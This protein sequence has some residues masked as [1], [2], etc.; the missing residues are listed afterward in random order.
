MNRL[1]IEIN[2]RNNCFKLIE[3]PLKFKE[4]NN[5]LRRLSLNI[6]TYIYDTSNIPIII[7]Y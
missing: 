4:T 6:I 3:K 2:H 1:C 7:Y 5:I